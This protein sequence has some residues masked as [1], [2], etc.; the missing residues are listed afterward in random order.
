M[1]QS[2][3]RANGD[4]GRCW[5]T[6]LV[7]AT[8]CMAAGCAP[9]WHLE[10]GEAETIARTAEQP[11]VVFYKAPFDVQSS[12]LQT[13]LEQPAMAPLLKGA[14]R[15]ML[16][17]EFPPDRKYVA[18]YGVLRAPAVILIHRDG[19][20]HAYQGPPSQDTLT[21]FFAQAKPPGAKPDLNP[22]IPRAIDYRWEGIYEDAVS[23]AQRQNR[24]LFIVYKWWLSAES[25]DLLNI[26]LTR[27][28]VARHFTETVNCLLDMDYLPNRTHMRQYGVTKVPSVVLVHRDGTY[29]AHSGEMT[30]EQLIRF[31]ST[32]KP[33]GKTP[34]SG[35]VERMR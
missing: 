13:V 21:T 18:Q 20:Y 26:C 12:Q 11:M 9:V 32:S 2:S 34:G 8:L 15:C 35:L 22:Q 29:H 24:E 27:P 5:L 33:P 19:T 3:L 16:T 7:S 28:E 6:V 1:G 17:T 23:K 4:Q 30:A 25:T 10:Y 14:V 31:V